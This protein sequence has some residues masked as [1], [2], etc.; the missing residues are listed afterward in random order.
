MADKTNPS[1]NSNSIDLSEDARHNTDVTPGQSGAMDEPKQLQNGTQPQG[2]ANE[3]RF[4][5][6]RED[7]QRNSAKSAGQ[8]AGGVAHNVAAAEGPVLPTGL[9][10]DVSGTI[11]VPGPRG[12]ARTRPATESELLDGEDLA[13]GD[14]VGDYRIREMIGRGGCGT[15][16]AAEHRAH[17]KPVAIKVLRLSLASSS[18]QV[19]RFVQEA[20]ALQLIDHPGIVDVY[21]TGYLHDGRPYFV[22]ELLE[23]RSLGT[24]LSE[25]GRLSPSE[26][27]EILEPV[28][29]MLGLAHAAGIVHR[30][31][32]ASNIM[33][34]MSA[35][36]RH[37]KLLDFGLAKLV[38]SEQ[39]G[40][41]QTSIGVVLGTLHSMAPEQ[42]MGQTVDGRTDIYALGALLHRLLTGRHPFE[43]I[44]AQKVANM[45]LKA[46]PPQPSQLAPVSP[47]LD[48]VVRRAMDKEPSGRF[49]T[50]GEFLAA[51]REAA[52][53][54]EP[55]L[56]RDGRAVAIYV[57]A[58]LAPGRELDDELFDRLM[59]MLDRTEVTLVEGQFQILLQTTN[60]LLAVR[61]VDERESATAAARNAIGQLPGHLET[62]VDMVATLQKAL[63]GIA[64]NNDF[65]VNICLHCDRATIRSWAD[66]SKVTGGRV[67]D[68]GIWAPRERFD[69]PCVTREALGA[70]DDNRP[71]MSLPEVLASQ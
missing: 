45:H 46:P 55:E 36:G 1:L 60:A 65:H 18:H 5:G 27:V 20:Q 40:S 3:R 67:A 10:A 22:M 42:I 14:E 21:D 52:G 26:A 68:I 16:Y 70:G 9:D 56:T 8:T 31:I 47:G 63:S 7:V 38:N 49:A 64:S 58:R 57:D 35:E 17:G 59:A 66:E 53:D 62:A 19:R 61:Q 33:V 34:T 12:D 2:K 69:D 28:C 48:A 43:G 30:D 39:S 23:G 29:E 41:M 32:K 71:Y 15:V 25:R 4:E 54:K 24:M 11:C 6:V 44:D 51:L 50:A 37:I 13:A